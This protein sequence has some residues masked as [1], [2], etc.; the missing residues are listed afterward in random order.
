MKTRAA[1]TPTRTNHLLPIALLLLTIGE[2]GFGAR[3]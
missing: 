2:S 3:V 1:S